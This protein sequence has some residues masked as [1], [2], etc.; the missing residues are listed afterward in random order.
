MKPSV[1]LWLEEKKRRLN[2]IPIEEELRIGKL[3]K[4]LGTKTSSSYRTPIGLSC[5]HS[6]AIS[7]NAAAILL[8]QNNFLLNQVI[9]LEEKLHCSEQRRR[10][11]GER[12]EELQ[13]ENRRFITRIA[14]FTSFR[15]GEELI[16]RE[17]LIREKIYGE[18]E[19]S[20]AELVY[21]FS[22]SLLVTCDLGITNCGREHRRKGART[23][24]YSPL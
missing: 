12:L 10:Q 17:E 22:R 7:I 3:K 20:R 6:T 21:C 2:S 24:A 4:R 13:E 15:D 11:E 19:R 23:A 16:L 18:Q 1:Q 8:E 5:S 9:E 14:V